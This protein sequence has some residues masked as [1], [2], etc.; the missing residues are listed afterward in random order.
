MSK[1]DYVY[2][3]ESDFPNG[4]GWCSDGFYGEVIEFPFYRFERGKYEGRTLQDLMSR[5]WKG[6]LKYIDYGFI[7]LTPNLFYHLNGKEENLRVLQVAC[8]AKQEFESISSV[9]DVLRSYPFASK[10]EGETLLSVA[11]S[12]PEYL[13]QLAKRSFTYY[14]GNNQHY[15]TPDSGLRFND[16]ESICRELKEH[17]VNMELIS[18]IREYHKEKEERDEIRERY[19]QD[20]YEAEM[21][22]EFLEDAYREA[23]NDDPDAE[24]NTY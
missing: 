3:Y 24:W 21:E 1:S 2:H 6:V 17:H 10:H 8:D 16:F 11:K 9:H 19:Y 20:R 23:Y 13:R 15:Y 5:S 18:Q 14:H 7:M 4:N 22:R 12:D